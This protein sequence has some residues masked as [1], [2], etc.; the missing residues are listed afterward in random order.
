[1]VKEY[2]LSL[3]PEAFKEAVRR[4]PQNRKSYEKDKFKGQITSVQ[5]EIDVSRRKLWNDI[6]VKHKKK[7][8]S[9]TEVRHSFSKRNGHL[10]F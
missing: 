6:D 8:D 5:K 1:M 3:S 9:L 10:S 7:Y 2:F 4:D